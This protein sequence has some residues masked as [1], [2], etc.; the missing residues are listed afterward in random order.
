MRGWF[1]RLI[2]GKILDINAE[3]Q[4][5]EEIRDQ[6]LFPTDYA[7]GRRLRSVTMLNKVVL[8]C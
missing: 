1:G 8:D 7:D 2:L 5:R 3:A 6:G 4:R